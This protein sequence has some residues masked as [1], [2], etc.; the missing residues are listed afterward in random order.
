MNDDEKDFQ[1]E[2]IQAIHEEKIKTQ[3][4]RANYITSKFAFITG[5][6]SLG[7]LQI[8][9]T[10]FRLLFYFIP[11]VAIGYD[12]YIRAA[13]LSIKKM[14]TFLR[15]DPLSNTTETEKAWERFSAS[16]RDKLAQLATTLFS[17]IIIGTAAISIYIL[18]GDE[19]TP[20]F[21]ILFIIWLGVSLVINTLLWNSHRSEVRRLDQK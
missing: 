21:T 15:S 9:Q 13:D 5:L 20:A 1:L 8:G 19:K 7:A 11:M 18:Q 14:G 2:F 6:F 16:H 10:N 4:E 17:Y 12:L 3:Q